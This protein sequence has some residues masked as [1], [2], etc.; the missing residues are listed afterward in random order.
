M[1]RHAQIFCFS[2]DHALLS[3]RWNKI[4][5]GKFIFHQYPGGIFYVPNYFSLSKK[6]KNLQWH[7]LNC[8]QL[9]I[10]YAEPRMSA[11]TLIN[12]A[13]GADAHSDATVRPQNQTVTTQVCRWDADQFAHILRIK[14]VSDASRVAVTSEKPLEWRR[15]TATKRSGKWRKLCPLR[16]PVW[17]KSVILKSKHPFVLS[18]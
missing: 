11:H 7:I 18:E 15:Q 2:T 8:C 13:V 1:K 17:A 16:L 3:S 4:K 12:S 6:K 14:T 9:N 5:M 10:Q